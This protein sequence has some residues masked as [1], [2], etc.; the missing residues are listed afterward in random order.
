MQVRLA[1]SHASFWGGNAIAL[2]GKVERAPTELGL[3]D[4]LISHMGCRAG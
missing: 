3:A 1:V 2:L 4:I